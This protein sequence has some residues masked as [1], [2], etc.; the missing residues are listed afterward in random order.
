MEYAIYGMIILSI[1][2]F[3]RKKDNVQASIN[4]K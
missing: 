4:G 1:W 2:Q 3:Q